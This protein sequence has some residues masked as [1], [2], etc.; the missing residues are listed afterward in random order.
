MEISHIAGMNIF[1]TVD[2][3]TLY[4]L[5]TP[6]S[7]KFIDG[8]VSQPGSLKL[9]LSL[10]K[11]GTVAPHDMSKSDTN[12]SIRSLLN[13]LISVFQGNRIVRF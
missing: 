9:I 10:E 7:I 12:R 13:I 5:I 6:E 3:L 4:L 1:L 2:S 8:L 11:N